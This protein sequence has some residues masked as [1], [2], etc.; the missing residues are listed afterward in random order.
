MTSLP[1]TLLAALALSPGPDSTLSLS[2]VVRRA[3]DHDPSLQASAATGD[4]ARAAVGEARA[5]WFPVVALSG[6]ATQY[7]EP[8]IATPIHGFEPD[9]IPPFDETL[10]QAGVTLQYTL[11]DGGARGARLRG[12]RARSDAALAALDDAAQGVVARGVRGYLA[13]L[14]A[15]QV[16]DAHDRRL[17]ALD[18]ELG[19]V[20]LRRD[21]GRAA[22]VEVLR[23]E[24]TLAAARAERVRAAAGLDVAERELARLVGVPH[25]SARADRLIA[26]RGG[27]AP[28]PARE[29]LMT[30]ALAA[31][32]ALERARREQAAAAAGRAIAGAARWPTLDLFGAYMDRGG[33]DTEHQLEWNVGVQLSYPIFTGGAVSGAAARADAESRAAAERVRAVEQQVAGDVDRALAAVDEAG[34]RVVSLETAVARFAEV[35]RIELL[36]LDAGSGTQTDYLGA[37]ADLLAARAALADARHG[38]IAARAELARV[39]GALDLAWVDQLVEMTP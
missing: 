16:L 3:L 6:S 25:D 5:R 22:D 13:V 24:A 26:V 21:A 35:A 8:M 37:E 36:R 2:E 17:A 23:V 39:I 7:Q 12:A 38:A 20:R 28:V 30:R 29:D 1:W 10:F 31:S 19:R 33:L 32:P 34:A 14:G 4:A 15:R 11:L 9:R 18:A 27:D